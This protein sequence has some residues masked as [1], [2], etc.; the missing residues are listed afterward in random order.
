MI[1]IPLYV[2]SLCTNLSDLT[3]IVHDLY[4]KSDYVKLVLILFSC[5]KSH[6]KG[7]LTLSN[8]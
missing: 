6:E 7:H 8:Y 5:A 1:I 4:S 2:F 3:G